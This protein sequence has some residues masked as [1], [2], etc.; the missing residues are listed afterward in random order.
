MAASSVLKAHDVRLGQPY[1][2][3]LEQPT[4]ARP[5]IWGGG[6]ALETTETVSMGASTGQAKAKLIDQN[7]NGA[8]IEVTC[9]CGQK[10]QLFCEYAVGLPQK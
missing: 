10:I 1:Q 7:A 3:K 5:G 8:T 6:E 2:A 4:P 9:P